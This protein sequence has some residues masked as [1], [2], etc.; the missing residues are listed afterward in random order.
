[1]GQPGIYFN[2]Y[3]MKNLK[4]NI[5]LLISVISLGT[6]CWIYVSGKSTSRKIAYVRSADV[7]YGYFG[8]K[9]AQQDLKAK[10]DNWQANID[11]LQKDYQASVSRY[12][13]EVMK[14]QPKEKEAFED[15]LKKEQKN[16]LGYSQAINAKAKSEDEK[17]TQGVLN[18][19]NS[20]VEAYGKT[21]NYEIILGTT[22][23][24]SILYGDN[25]IDIT[26][27][28]LDGLNRDY[29]GGK[30]SKTEILSDDKGE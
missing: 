1:M 4:T 30:T 11:T 26:K 7:V 21:H 6:T 13:A 2:Q 29:K 23:S 8:M 22:L 5:A 25:T 18:Q 17:M 14:L 24:G 3:I 12:S 9:E 15:R 20:Y 28:V 19:I 27:E 16:L 10:T